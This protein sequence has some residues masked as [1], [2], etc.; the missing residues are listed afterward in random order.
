[1]NAASFSSLSYFAIRLSTSDVG[2]FYSSS[3]GGVASRMTGAAAWA[4]FALSAWETSASA[5]ESAATSEV[6][7]FI[8]APIAASA[9]SSSES[10]DEFLFK[11]LIPFT[12]SVVIIPKNNAIVNNYA[13]IFY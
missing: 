4:V 1:M 5:Y 12:L 13:F 8:A 9:L 10:C 2:D 7:A 11:I 3:G 6:S